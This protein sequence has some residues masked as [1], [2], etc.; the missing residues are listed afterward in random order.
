M[1]LGGNNDHIFVFRPNETGLGNAEGD[2]TKA[3]LNSSRKT[4][5]K[6]IG[7]NNAFDNNTI[8]YSDGSNSGIVINVVSETN[9]SVTFN[10]T[11]PKLEGNGSKSTP[12]L[13]YDVDTFL[14]LMKI[15]T[16]NKYYKLMNDLDF[17]DVKD[18]PKIDFK[19]SLDGNNKTLKNISAIG[20][21]VFNSV[22][23]YGLNCLVENL[24]VEN[25]NITPGTGNYLGGFTGAAESI[26]LRNIHLKSGTVK[27][28]KSQ[29]NDISSTGGFAGNVSNDTIIDNCSSSLDV[30]SEKNVGGFIGINMNA[31]I[32]NCYTN[33]K[34]SGNSNVGGFIGL[35]AIKNTAYK[36]PEKVYFDYSKTKISNAVGGYASAF[37]SLTILP[38]DNLGKGIVGISV[39]E[40]VNVNGTGKLNYNI[41]TTPN[42]SLQFSVSTSD[43]TIIKYTNNTIQGVKNGNAKIYVDLKVGTKV[44]RM[45]S[46]VKVANIQTQNTGTGGGTGNSSGTNTGTGSKP[47]TSTGTGTG[48]NT[49]NNTNIEISEAAVLKHFG[50]TK[51][52][53]YIVGFKLGERVSNIRK[54]LSSY[55]NVTLSSFK[56]ASGNEIRDGIVSTNMKFTLTFN[57]KQY[58]YTIIIK[59]D[60]NGDG[61]IYAT[62]YVRIKNHIME[63][64]KLEGA[65]L[66]AADINNDNNIYATDYVKIKN[67]I[68]G[69][70][71]IEQK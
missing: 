28:I 39:P 36:T 44:M 35:Q 48:S 33:G 6:E 19:G 62:D 51:K 2:L 12:Y 30:T 68:M 65:Y 26:T 15:E 20:T 5:G 13:I 17:K 71:K 21:G 43:S 63:K 57:K 41:T 34:V 59:G 32:K 23:Y 69:K 16:K 11:F 7:E 4:L 3:T 40:Q 56:N 47:G 9:N 55:P 52:D 49:G 37:H 38:A 50:L 58:N 14:Y 10:V 29:Y 1:L 66:K 54:I 70:G 24:N 60:V 46:N 22:G 27:N 61:T 42:T 18:Y 31:T 45:E 53:G 8:Y 25:I 67:Y 64:K